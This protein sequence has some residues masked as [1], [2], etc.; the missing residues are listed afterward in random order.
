MKELLIMAGLMLL[1]VSICHCC[2]LA[3]DWNRI[4]A[5]QAADA[6]WLTDRQT[7]LGR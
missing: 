7:E 3:H 6:A 5:E 2:S 4:Q 1:G